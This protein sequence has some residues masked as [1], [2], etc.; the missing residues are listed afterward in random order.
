[1]RKLLKE[2]HSGLIAVEQMILTPLIYMSL[3]MMLYFFFAVMAYIT[4]NNIANSMA[5]E[6][7]MRQ[8]GYQRCIDAYQNICPT[9]YSYR[10]IVNA[11]NSIGQNGGYILS[12]ANVKVGGP[13]IQDIDNNANY[14]TP[15]L[16]NGTYYALDK[17]SNG[18]IIPFTEVKSVKVTSTKPVRCS[19]G[20]KMAGNVIRVEIDYTSILSFSDSTAPIFLPVMKAVGYNVIS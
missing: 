16:L 9:I 6:L 1:M 10:N 11:D 15:E 20:E 3:I 19:D 2:E 18:F 8:T 12:P 5:A 4:F 14:K 7:N 13:T 17:Y